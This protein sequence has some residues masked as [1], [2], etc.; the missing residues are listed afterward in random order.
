MI[1]VREWM[2][3]KRVAGALAALA[4]LAVAAGAGGVDLPAA[5][6]ILGRQGRRQQQGGEQGKDADHGR[7]Q[8][9]QDG[10]ILPQARADALI[11]D[12]AGPGPPV[13]PKN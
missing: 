2:R 10:A 8:G 12:Q 9:S 1:P 3:D 6:R 5:L 11:R 13:R 7:T 4:V